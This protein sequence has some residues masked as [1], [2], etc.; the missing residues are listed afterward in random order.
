MPPKLSVILCTY[1]RAHCLP[2]TLESLTRQSLEPGHYE[3]VIVD[4]ASSDNTSVVIR[5]FEAEH[6]SADILLLSESTQGLAHARNTGCKA[7]RGR[8]LAFIDDDCIASEDWL[9]TVLA[10]YEQVRPTPISVGGSIFPRYD[11]PGPTWFKDSYETETWGDQPRFL[12][13][14]ESFTGCNMSFTKAVIEQ[15][16]GFPSNYGMKGDSLALGEETHL[17]RHIWSR[18]KEAATFYY[19]PRAVVYHT[20]DPYKMTVSYQLKRALIAG[21]VSCWM[22]QS[23]SF[24]RKSILFGGSIALLIFQTLLAIFRMGRRQGWQNWAVEELCSVAGQCGRL[25]AFFSV[26]L[27]FSQRDTKLRLADPGIKPQSSYA[28]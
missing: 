8:Y 24:P 11:S 14:G 6:T 13:T 23:D 25:L 28:S 7:A 9:E 3:I 18:D 5:R 4:N 1:N 19:T 27:T 26:K 15:F 12:I 10:C 22:S 20:I 21:Q 16:G 2:R 17:F